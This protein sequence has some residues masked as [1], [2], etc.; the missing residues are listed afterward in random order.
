MTHTFALLRHFSF[1]GYIPDSLWS[2]YD[3]SLTCFTQPRP[4]SRPLDMDLQSSLLT[5][6]WY[7]SPW[8]ILVSLWLI[9]V[10]YSF[11]L[12][13]DTAI[14]RHLPRVVQLCCRLLSTN[15]E[16]PFLIQLL[17]EYLYINCSYSL[18]RSPAWPRQYTALT[19]ERSRARQ[20]I[21]T[22][23]EILFSTWTELDPWS[24]QGVRQRT[25]RR[26][27]LPSRTFDLDTRSPRVSSN[28]LS[29]WGFALTK[30][31]RQSAQ[32]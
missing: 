32:I 29:S 17:V 10:S 13:F 16:T 1:L 15:R 30:V 8:Q 25:R 26:N 11:L 20:L 3:V 6:T 9:L 27:P 24:P 7:V 28:L 2:W 21:D 14:D 12:L 5:D 23:K 19:P 18:A 4:L 22:T 31:L